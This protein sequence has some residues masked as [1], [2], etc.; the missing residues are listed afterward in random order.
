MHRVPQAIRGRGDLV[1]H[2]VRPGVVH[3]CTQTI[4]IASRGPSLYGSGDGG[5]T[6]Y[7]LGHAPLSWPLGACARLRPVARAARWQVHH[8]RLLREHTVLVAG[9][10]QFFWVN[11]QSGQWTSLGPWVGSRPLTIC[12][13]RT[14]VYYG[15]Y[16]RNAGRGPVSVYRSRDGGRSWET[17]WAFCDVRHVH[18]VY[19]DPFTDDVWVTTGDDDRECGIWRTSD[20]FHTLRR[21]IG[22]H[23]QTRA[24]DLV[25]TADHVYFGS[26]TEREPNHIYRFRRDAPHPEPVCRVGGPILH[27]TRSAGCLLFSTSCEPNTVDGPR[28]VELWS[29]S[30]GVQWRRRAE[31]P[32][33]L[34]P[35]RVFQYGQVLFAHGAQSPFWLSLLGCKPDHISLA[36]S[37]PDEMP[38]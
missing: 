32:K 34:L 30:D 3:L 38:V 7:S 27:G 17:A 10:G 35:A 4:S 14:D 26:D 37:L 15:E 11:L 20:R 2:D 13:V 8:V 9:F 18:G 31:F 36:C 5:A 23:Q 22:G 33:D 12:T 16:G 21:V 19:H 24:V 29:S 25:F 28:A 6:W 1:V